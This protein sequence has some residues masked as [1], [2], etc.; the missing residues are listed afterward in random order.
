MGENTFWPNQCSLR[1]SAFHGGFFSRL[2]DEICVP[3]LDDVLVFSK[4]FEE[5][6]QHLKIVLN[7]LSSRG[8][9]LKASKCK[10]FQSEV[11]YLGHVVSENG[12]RRNLSNIEAITSFQDKPPGTIDE[13]RKLL[14]LLGYYRKHIPTSG[15]AKGC[16]LSSSTQIQWKDVNQAA[17]EL[18]IKALTSPPILAYPDFTRQCILHT[19][20][21]KDGLGPESNWIWITVFDTGRKKLSDARR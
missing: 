17:L 11:G 21:S 20:A 14:D 16:Q 19:D 2:L 7:R 3:Y 13:L 15:N 4:S 9:K 18:L 1:I 12:Y 8:V 10:I 5:H 6:V